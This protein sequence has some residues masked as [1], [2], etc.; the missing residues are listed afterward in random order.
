MRAGRVELWPK[1][2]VLLTGRAVMQVTGLSLWYFGLTAIPLADATALGLLEPIFA[3][4]FAIFF[5]K[6]KTSRMEL[7]GIALV[8][9]AIVAIILTG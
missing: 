1:R 5:F 2:P 8:M 3:A 7:A 4:L 6:E 9:I